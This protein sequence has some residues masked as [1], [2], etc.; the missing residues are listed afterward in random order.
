[1]EH[2][3]RY[4]HAVHFPP[5]QGYWPV[6]SLAS[7]MYEHES[8]AFPTFSHTFSGSDAEQARSPHEYRHQHVSSWPNASATQQAKYS[9]RADM[10]PPRGLVQPAP[11]PIAASRP[12]ES[13]PPAPPARVEPSAQ[14]PRKLLTDADRLDMCKFAE[15]N[16]SLKQT[17]IG[18]TYPT[19][20]TSRLLLILI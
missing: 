4:G 2:D 15:S 9:S 7:P 10:S 20:P 1:M 16:P 12:T 5:S 13:V 19:S 11:Q 3:Q 6:C 17:D 14:T 8:S 18:G